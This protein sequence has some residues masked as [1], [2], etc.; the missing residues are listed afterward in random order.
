[1]VDAKGVVDR[2]EL[3]KIVFKDAIKRKILQRLTHKRI[4]KEMFLEIFKLR[5]VEL[6]QLVVLDAPLLFET[7]FLEFVTGPIVV[8]H[9]PD[10]AKQR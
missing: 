3:G 8:V 1:M 10:S 7:K 5:V 4:F 2:T 9:T 6:K